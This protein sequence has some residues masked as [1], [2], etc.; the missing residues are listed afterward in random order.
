VETRHFLTI[1][2]VISFS[3]SNLQFRHKSLFGGEG[4]EED[5]LAIQSVTALYAISDRM[6]D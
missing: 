6:N 3:K 1:C 4:V 5:Y 2:S